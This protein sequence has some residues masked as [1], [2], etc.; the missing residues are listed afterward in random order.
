MESR[1]HLLVKLGYRIDNPV[2]CAT[3][4]QI[5]AHALLKLFAGQCDRLIGKILREVAGHAALNLFEHRYRRTNLP[6][7][8]IT[9]LEAI[10]LDEGFLQGVKRSLGP[11][12]L[13]GRDRPAF[14]LHRE[15]QAGE[16]S[17]AIDKHR[18]GAAGTL[19]TAFFC[20]GEI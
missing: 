1:I 20:S 4:T 17:L 3:P 11:E 12:T 19:I 5:P 8:A 9:A 7:R 10:V 16:D 6:G 13:D 2:V 15:G 14:V 18:A